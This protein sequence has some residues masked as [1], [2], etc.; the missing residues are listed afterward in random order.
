MGDTVAV[1]VPEL[2]GSL[3]HP[4]RWYPK[5][6]SPLASLGLACPFGHEEGDEPVAAGIHHPEDAVVA[7]R[8]E[9]RLLPQ[10]AHESLMFG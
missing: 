5:N 2:A 4:Q 6:R 9:P 7:L 3:E 8:D 1:I 10:L